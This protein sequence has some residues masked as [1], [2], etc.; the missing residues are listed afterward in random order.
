MGMS[1]LGLCLAPTPIFFGS[2]SLYFFPNIRTANTANTRPHLVCVWL[3]LQFSLALGLFI[4]SRTHER[5]TRRTHVHTWFVFGSNSN[6]LWL[7]VSLFLPEQTNG[8]HGEHTS[9]LGLCLA[10]G[11]FVSSR[12]HERRTQ[13]THVHTWFV[14]GSTSNFLW[15]WVSLF[16][17]EHTNGE[18]CEHTSTLGCVWLWVSLILPE[19]TNGEHGEHTSTLGCVLLWVFLFLP[20]HTNGEHGEHTST[21]GLCLAPT[22]T[23]FGS[24]SLYFF[25]NTRTA[26]TANTR[27]NLVCVWLHLQ[28]S[29]A[30]DLFIS[31]RTHE[32]R[33]QRTHVH[34]WSVLGSG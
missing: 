15:L 28:L 27:P 23:F 32:R 10:L 7:W 31:S 17:P 22:P 14:F 34:T 3:Q 4:S 24:G 1:T 5:R 20:E 18:H 16:L 33:T 29:L 9:T 12:T 11:L 25:P 8:E 13:R 21:L 26:N 2:G 30:L 6:F 19:H